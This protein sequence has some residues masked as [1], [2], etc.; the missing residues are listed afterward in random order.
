MTARRET[1]IYRTIFI[2]ANGDLPH[3]CA[4][5]GDPILE[6]GTGSEHGNI[7]HIDGDWT[8][9]DPSNL[10]PMHVRCHHSHHWDDTLGEYSRSPKSDKVRAKISA[11]LTG[12]TD[13]PEV[14]RRKSEAA[15]ASYAAGRKSAG[16]RPKGSIDA[17]APC[18]ICGHGVTPANMERHVKSHDGPPCPDCGV[19][20]A[21]MRT[22]KR[23]GRCI[24]A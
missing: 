14:R 8:N 16:G 6:W 15:K 19:P 4:D 10:E 11:S 3:D 22:H 9:N 24:T 18:E 20:Y 1:I 5:C 17:T 2:K 12:R 23:A 13:P 21:L 7:H